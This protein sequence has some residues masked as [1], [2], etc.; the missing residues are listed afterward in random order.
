MRS[1]AQPPKWIAPVESRAA[2][3]N[4]MRTIGRARTAVQRWTPPRSNSAVNV[5][6]IALVGSDPKDNASPHATS[7]MR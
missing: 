5:R 3:S 7:A 2:E 6:I 1:D 4:S